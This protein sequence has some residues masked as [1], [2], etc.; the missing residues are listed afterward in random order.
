MATRQVWMP[1][2]LLIST[3]LS[4]EANTS[5]IGPKPCIFPVGPTQVMVRRL[6]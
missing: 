2:R 3:F 4:R 1:R 6:K 5:G